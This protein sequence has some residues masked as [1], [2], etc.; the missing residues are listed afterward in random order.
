[1]PTMKQTVALWP[2][3]TQEIA[4]EAYKREIT[5]GTPMQAAAVIG[6]GEGFVLV[7]GG[8]LVAH[9]VAVFGVSAACEL[10][11]TVANNRKPDAAS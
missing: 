2:K 8:P 6:F 10:D 5:A 4:R 7:Y 9:A 3:E 1:M 11:S